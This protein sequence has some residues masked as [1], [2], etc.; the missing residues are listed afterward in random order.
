VY[1]NETISNS[2]RHRTGS[3]QIYQRGYFASGRK[4]TERFADLSK[5]E[6]EREERIK[7]CIDEEKDPINFAGALG[8]DGV[9]KKNFKE[10][11][12]KDD[13][14]VMEKSDKLVKDS[15]EVAR[16]VGGCVEEE[17]NPKKFAEVLGLDKEKKGLKYNLEVVE[18]DGK[19]IKSIDF[20]EN[21]EI[22]KTKE[23]LSPK[24][25][26]V[27]EFKTFKDHYD[28]DTVNVGKYTSLNLE[29][30]IKTWSQLHWTKKEEIIKTADK[31]TLSKI[32]EVESSEKIIKR[33]IEKARPI[34]AP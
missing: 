23:A 29:N 10:N 8:I 27:K 32:K 12:I 4:R 2:K 26:D 13:S 1:D 31:T 9:A 19:I 5:K 34:A 15:R 22:S 18:E 28:A 17:K 6:K 20:S 33:I 21:P 24:K 30:T 25:K 16:F 7:G 3:I 14:K 11:F